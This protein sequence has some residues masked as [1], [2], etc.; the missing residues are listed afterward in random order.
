MEFIDNGIV[1]YGDGV[2][3]VVSEEVV[4]FNDEIKSLINQMYEMLE[5]TRGV[6]VAGPQVGVAKRVFVYDVGEGQHA[7]INPKIIK[8]SG[9]EIS[10][11]GCLSIPG[12]QGDVERAFRVTVTGIDENGKKVKIKADGLLARCF[13]HEIDHLDGK[14]FIDRADPQTLHYITPGDESE[15]DEEYE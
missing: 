5:E 2:L 3:R 9:E 1:K 7:L 15:E 12:L 4:D 14:L 13:Q 11:E 8:S 6:G 10:V